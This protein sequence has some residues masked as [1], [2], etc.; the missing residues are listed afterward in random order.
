MGTA[1]TDLINV[2]IEKYGKKT[3]RLYRYKYK[4]NENILNVK[5]LMYKGSFLMKNSKNRLSKQSIIDNWEDKTEAVTVF[6]R[7]TPYSIEK[8]SIFFT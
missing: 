3:E 2:W 5:K 1:R 6:I 8:L 7:I 4:R